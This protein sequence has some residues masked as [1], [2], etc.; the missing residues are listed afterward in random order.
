MTEQLH[1]SLLRLRAAVLARRI[2]L[3]GYQL[4]FEDAQRWVRSYSD[5]EAFRSAL[6][7]LKSKPFW[8]HFWWNR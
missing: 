3:Q 4:P 6:H 2:K 5:V 1:T 8:S 7:Q